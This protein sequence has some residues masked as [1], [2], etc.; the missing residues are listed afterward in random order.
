M[1]N[2]LQRFTVVE[3][4][5]W[6]PWDRAWYD[7]GTGEIGIHWDDAD[8]GFVLA[9][10]GA[11]ALGYGE[12]DASYFGQTCSGHTLEGSPLLRSF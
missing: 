4:L 7:T 2:Y 3:W 1:Q 8:E 9:H 12:G 11:H 10:E 6:N 5:G